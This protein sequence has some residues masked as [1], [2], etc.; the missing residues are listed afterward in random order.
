MNQIANVL[1]LQQQQKDTSDNFGCWRRSKLDLP[2]PIVVK[3][4]HII[5][6]SLYRRI[7]KF[8]NGRTF[9]GWYKRF[10]DVFDNDCGDLGDN[11][12]TRLLVSR[13]DEDCHQLF[14]GSISPMLPSDLTRDEAIATLER[15][16]GQD[17][18]AYET[19]CIVFVAGFQGAEFANYRTRMLRNRAGIN[20]EAFDQGSRSLMPAHQVLQGGR[21][22]AGNFDGQIHGQ[23]EEAQIQTTSRN[24]GSRCY[25][26][27]SNI[28]ALRKDSDTV[29]SAA[30]GKRKDLQSH[31]DLQDSD[32]V[33]A[34]PT[35]IEYLPMDDSQ[36]TLCLGN[37]MVF[38]IADVDST[39][40]AKRLTFS[41]A[42][43]SRR[44][45]IPLFH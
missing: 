34:L 35:E 5:F 42:N 16:F 41:S 31:L 24:H 2:G 28:A 18:N 26:M 36:L 9:D 10:K 23:E 21:E 25:Q 32:T 14:C 4:K 20:L 27:K 22:D 44:Y 33:I 45:Q 13:L 19:L 7:E 17:F 39:I 3:D 37:L 12:K 43:G 29:I 8:T 11:E 6:N 15:L 38:S 30:N 1:V 40:L